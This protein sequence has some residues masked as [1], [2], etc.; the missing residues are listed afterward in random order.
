MKRLQIGKSSPKKMDNAIKSKKVVKEE[1]T[2]TKIGELEDKI[3]ELEDNWKRA[4]ADYRNLEKRMADE[5]RDIILFANKEFL[6]RLLP[7]FDMLFLAEKHVNDEGLKITIKGLND[8]LKDVG[9]ERVKTIDEEF[10]PQTMECVEKINEGSKVL[11]ELRPGFLLNGRLLRP[12][13][14]KVGKEEK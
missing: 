10:D 9:V 7:A 2:Q 13:M 12:A 11:Q 1:K 14:V 3:K 4:V 8:V 5:R 6:N